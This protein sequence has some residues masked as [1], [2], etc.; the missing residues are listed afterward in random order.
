MDIA[1]FDLNQAANVLWFAA[2][3][4]PGDAIFGGETRHF[5][6]ATAA[7]RFVM[8]ELTDFP[9]TSARITTDAGSLTLEE[10]T[11]LYSQLDRK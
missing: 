10:I 11:I 9:H 7:I 6:S 4:P 2:P 5:E 1:S 3:P 8:E